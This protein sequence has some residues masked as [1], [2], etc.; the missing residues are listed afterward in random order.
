MSPIWVMLYRGKIFH[1][2]SV[3]CRQIKTRAERKRPLQGRSKSPICCGPH[4]SILTYTLVTLTI[5]LS[6]YAV[7]LGIPATAASGPQ[8]RPGAGDWELRPL[9]AESA[10]GRGCHGAQ[11]SSRRF[12]LGSGRQLHTTDL[13]GTEATHCNQ[14]RVWVTQCMP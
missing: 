7:E 1:L 13:L 3:F 2:E 12:L 11:L 8:W 5:L 10:L 4:S 9:W 6:L 14:G